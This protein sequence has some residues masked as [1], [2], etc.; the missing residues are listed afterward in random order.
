[1]PC[2][3]N[4]APRAETAAVDDRVCPWHAGAMQRLLQR[5][6]AERLPHALLLHGAPGT[7]KHGFAET[8]AAALLCTGAG[9]QSCGTCRNCELVAAGNHPDLY[10]VAPAGPGKA[11]LIEAVRDLV[12]FVTGTP[13]IARRRV[14]LIGPAEAM[15]RAAANAL[16]KTLEEPGRDVHLLLVSSAPALVMPTIR[17]RCE[18]VPL[19]APEPGEATAWLASRV[20]DGVD[21]A[22]L[23][24]LSGGAPLHAL[25]LVDDDSREVRSGWLADLQALTEGRLTAL[26]VADRWRAGDLGDLLDCLYAWMHRVGGLMA[27]GDRCGNPALD[28]IA[29]HLSAAGLQGLVGF[30]ERL[31]SGR[32][33]VA[34]GA[35]PNRQLLLEDLLLA[36][37]PATGSASVPRVL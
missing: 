4:M 30:H 20:P 37:P 14:I 7:G 36:W 22:H 34:G 11:I 2:S 27:R 25:A 12:G 18:Q 5:A 28:A 33:A 17:S 23:L 8:L 6:V 35:H 31:V 10:R 16:L 19:A 26:E 29:G 24:E 9:E 1:M 21:P 13:M 3:A 15:N 32:R